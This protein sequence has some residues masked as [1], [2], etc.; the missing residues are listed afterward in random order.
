VTGYKLTLTA[1]ESI[2]SVSY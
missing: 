1:V 2:V